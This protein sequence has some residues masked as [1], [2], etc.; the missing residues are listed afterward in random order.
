MVTVYGALIAV[1]VGVVGLTAPLWWFVSRDA[2]GPWHSATWPGTLALAAQAAAVV[3]VFPWFVH[4][5]V[6][7]DRALVRALLE[8]TADS[9]RVATLERSRDHLVDDAAS[10]L[11]RIERDLH[12]GTQARFVTLGMALARLERHLDDS[13]MAREILAAARPVVDDGLTELR[14][15][16][17]GMHPPALDDGLSVA[18]VTLASRSPIPTQ[19]HDGLQTVPSASVASA[20]YFAAAELLTNSARHARA[21]R[22]VVT[23]D[24]AGEAVRLTVSDDGHGGAA[25]HRASGTGLDGLRRRAEALDG[26]LVVDSPPGGPT[27]VV[28]TLPR[29]CS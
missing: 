12:D 5:L 16:I 23:L 13:A 1:V 9:Q 14:E 19:V 27:R 8:P 6:G 3:L 4:F 29:R 2:W 7:L 26:T 22:V 15:I 24:E 10:R 28:M 25:D 11:A 17:R 21:S 18:L 20:L